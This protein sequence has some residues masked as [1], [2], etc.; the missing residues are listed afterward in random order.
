MHRV[1][2][3]TAADILPVPQPVG[4]KPNGY[5]QDQTIVDR[6]FMNA[7]Q[8]E[9]SGVI[10]T[11]GLALD[12]TLFNQLYSALVL[13][14]LDD[15]STL[16]KGV[17]ELATVAETQAGIDATRAVT[18]AGLASAITK[19]MIDALGIDAATLLGAAPSDT[20]SASTIAK[21]NAS[22]HI[23]AS[24]FHTTANF[25]TLPASSVMIETDSDGFIRRQT[26]QQLLSNL[27]IATSNVAGGLNTMVIEIG[28]WNMD[29]TAQVNIAHGLTLTKIRSISAVIRSDDDTTYT[30]F[31]T[32]Q[33]YTAATTIAKVLFAYSTHIRLQRHD[34]GYFDQAIFSATPFNRGW[35]TITYVD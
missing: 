21:R 17:V 28:D 22:G 1:D 31:A 19:S 13:L 27:N 4:P 15:A 14:G 18:P 23:L 5:F 16:F 2:G 24:Y 12:K 9:I 10:E 25:T 3:Q 8:E 34:S 29:I 20:Q 33:S 35:I 32:T 7:I 26:P 30:D 11:A 6:D